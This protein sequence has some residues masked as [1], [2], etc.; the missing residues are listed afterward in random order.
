[1]SFSTFG[2]GSVISL[3]LASGAASQRPPWLPSY[4]RGQFLAAVLEGQCVDYENSRE[5]GAKS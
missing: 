3:T 5:H 1:V 4:R 2:G